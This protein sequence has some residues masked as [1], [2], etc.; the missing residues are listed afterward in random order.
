MRVLRG[1]GPEQAVGRPAKPAK[2]NFP[3]IFH[4]RSIGEIVDDM[5][6]RRWE[7]IRTDMIQVAGGVRPIEATGIIGTTRGTKRPDVQAIDKKFRRVHVEVD[8]DVRTSIDHERRIFANDRIVKRM[9][10]AGG[11]W[12]RGVFIIQSNE[13]GHVTSVRHVDPESRPRTVTMDYARVGGVPLSW[14]LKNGVLNH[15][16][17]P[18]VR[19]LRGAQRARE[20][21]LLAEFAA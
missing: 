9:G 21:E 17:R 6:T 4:W 1:D 13:T 15:P 18:P 11:R 16:V 12:S 7:D 8:S 20:T 2:A 19:P 10:I 5:R 14:L 3:T